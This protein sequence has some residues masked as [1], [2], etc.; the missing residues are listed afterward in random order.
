MASLLLDLSTFLGDFGGEGFGVVDFVE[1]FA[2]LF[3][4]PADVFPTPFTHVLPELVSPELFFTSELFSDRLSSFSELFFGRLS[5]LSELFFDLSSLPELV[6]ESLTLFDTVLLSD[7]FRKVGDIDRVTDP[8]LE[9]SLLLSDSLLKLLADFFGDLD[10]P[11]LGDP[12]VL[13][14][15]PL[16]LRLLRLLIL[17]Q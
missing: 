13:P 14:L 3:S 1:G 17:S 8:E 4:V 11:G 2:A 9:V 7:G 6:S 12:E 5:S 16:T 10:L 15:P